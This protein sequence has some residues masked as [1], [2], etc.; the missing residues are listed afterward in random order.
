MRI[1]SNR[2]LRFLLH[3]LTNPRIETETFLVVVALRET[4][5]KDVVA[6]AETK[7][8]VDKLADDLNAR[9]VITARQKRAS[10]LRLKEICLPDRNGCV[11]VN[12]VDQF[13]VPF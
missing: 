1:E 8:A 2:F 11:L 7:T 12:H 6:V 3:C 9:V 13:V 4:F 10:V 5:E